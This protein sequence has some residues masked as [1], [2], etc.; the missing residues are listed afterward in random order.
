MKNGKIGI[1]RAQTT[2][3]KIEDLFRSGNK[4][5]EIDRYPRYVILGNIEIY[6][7]DE[8][9]RKM[10]GLRI[11]L[12]YRKDELV[13]YQLFGI[14]WLD[15]F[16]ELDYHTVF[17]IFSESS[18]EFRTL[19]YIDDTLG[20][21]NLTKHSKVLMLFKDNGDLESFRLDFDGYPYLALLKDLRS[22][23]I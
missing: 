7:H 20:I 8:G 18:L 4:I 11:K 10:S 23:N 21:L 1:F 3:E 12:S 13:P 6:F 16:S 15:W 9:M 2:I 22:F 17:Q 19:K 5:P 14:S